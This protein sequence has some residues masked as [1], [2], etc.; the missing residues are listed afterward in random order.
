MN[1][2]VKGATIATSAAPSGADW[3]AQ[4]RTLSHGISVGR[5]TDPAF[6][7]L[8]F[9]KLWS[10]VWQAAARL[11]E[12]PNPGD[13]MV[14]DIGD[15]S[16]LVVRTDADTI[17]AYHNV[18][19]HRGTALGEG[20]GTFEKNQIQ[21]PFHGWRWN[22][23]GQIQ[24]VLERQEYKDGELRDS[25]VALRELK[26]EVWAGFVFISFAAD[27]QP[28]DE[29]IAPI[30]DVIEGLAI[31]DMRHYWWKGIPVEANW[32][33]AQEAFFETFHV[34][35]THPQLEIAGAAAVRGD[36]EE[37][38]YAHRA[39][40]YENFPHGHGRFYAGKKTPM[41]GDVRDART[42]D[43]VDD[44]AARL[45]LLVDGMDAMVLQ[46]DVDLL[47]SLKGKPIP[48]GSSLGGE[49]VKALYADAAAK[50]RPMPR[51][52]PEILGMWGGEVFI[53]PNL[54]ILPQAGNAM[55][56]RVRPDRADP[57]RCTFEIMSTRTMP[58]GEQPERAVCQGVTDQAD[59]DQV[60][61]IPR[62]DLGNIPRIQK[63]LRTQG[64]RH[65]WLAQEQEKMIVNMHQELDRY[66]VDTK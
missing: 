57:N 61:L 38:E 55:I 18:C 42:G 58:A 60:R 44:M 65:I 1:E 11:D 63:G 51:P 62:Q 40:A 36:I 16:A 9:E 59:P 10:R 53:F 20:C 17:K 2:V 56:Y 29:F 54:L 52:T 28:F 46:S 39:V 41:A 13:Y 49:Y 64:I 21:C 37:V 45:Q 8:E 43:P 25:D 5:Y 14:Y 66:L 35:Q 32:K 15:R 4:W 3:P 47:R 22:L 12:I 24:Y 27:P 31:A 23:E 33:V 30:R 6:L 26:V 7:K 34:P 50:G 48:E 19:P